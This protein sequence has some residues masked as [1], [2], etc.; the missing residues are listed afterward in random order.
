MVGFFKIFQYTILRSIELIR[1]G[2][3]FFVHRREHRKR[4]SIHLEERKLEPSSTRILAHYYYSDLEGLNFE[5]ASTCL[6]QD[7]RNIL[8]HQSAETDFVLH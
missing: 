6:N 4:L 1:L 3:Y 5:C 7:D 8:S 2:K